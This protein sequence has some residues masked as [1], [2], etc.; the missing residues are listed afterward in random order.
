MY[1]HT[2]PK[3]RDSSLYT[4][5]Y[6]DLRTISWRH[7]ISTHTHKTPFNYFIYFL[8]TGRGYLTFLN[9][10][11]CVPD[12][13]LWVHESMLEKLCL[14]LFSLCFFGPV[15]S[16]V[17][18]FFKFGNY[19]YYTIFMTSFLSSKSLNIILKKKFNVIIIYYFHICH[20][21][22]TFNYLYWV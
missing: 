9:T 17:K 15:S 7:F 22:L 11:R 12:I 16:Y 18:T 4:L 21:T 5:K 13:H 6:L 19:F 20:F 8:R 14:V 1:P 3:W 2:H 10:W